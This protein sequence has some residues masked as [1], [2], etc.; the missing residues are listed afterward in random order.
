MAHHVVGSPSPS[1]T[2]T[3]CLDSGSER[4]DKIGHLCSDEVEENCAP[5]TC[6]ES[7]HV[8][9]AHCVEP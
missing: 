1:R 3:N 2:L 9:P 7:S 4:V 8:E 6:E 5:S